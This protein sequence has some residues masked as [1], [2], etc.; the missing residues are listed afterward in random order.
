MSSPSVL[1]P[2]F[3]ALAP[4]QRGRLMRSTRKL[5]ALLGTTPHLIEDAGSS[6]PSQSPVRRPSTSSGTVARLPI[7]TQHSSRTES[8]SPAVVSRSRR[9]EVSIYGHS[10]SDSTTSRASFEL[11]P[12]PPTTEKGHTRRK[13]SLSLASATA[14]QKQ[15]APAPL[16]LRLQPVPG[17][18]ALAPASPGQST[19]APATPNT[20]TFDTPPTPMTPLTPLLAPNLPPQ[21]YRRKKMAKLARTL[22]ENGASGQAVTFACSD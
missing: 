17:P 3:N 4:E 15:D 1:P 12:E 21:E 18:S 20:A 10:P 2:T 8:P 9:R 13:P 14:R 6:S 7:G 16:L 19:S 11:A 5:G 22:G